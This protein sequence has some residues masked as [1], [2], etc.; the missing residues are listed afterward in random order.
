MRTR[1]IKLFITFLLIFLV[2][3][4]KDNETSIKKAE[5]EDQTEEGSEDA[6][7]GE[8]E[9]TSSKVDNLDQ[10]KIGEAITFEETTITLN[11]ARLEPGSEYEKPN[12]DHYLV[13]NLTAENNSSDQEFIMSSL[14]N[15][16]LKDDNDNAYSATI[17]TEGAGEQFDGDVKAGDTMT[18]DIPFDVLQSDT[19]ELYFS[20][21]FDSG[22]AIWLIDSED[23]IK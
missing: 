3:G 2:V 23:L 22:E 17:L 4:C 8:N 14:L 11:E 6:E 20:N 7:T 19:Y 13:V 9:T 12:N 1:T 18:G 5:K 15:V 10:L 21:P 16:E